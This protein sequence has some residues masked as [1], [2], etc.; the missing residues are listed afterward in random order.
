MATIWTK[1]AGIASPFNNFTAKATG[2]S[3]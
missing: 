1:L 2:S 3:D